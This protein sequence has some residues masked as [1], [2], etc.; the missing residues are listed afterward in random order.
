MKQVGNDFLSYHPIIAPTLS[1]VP[2]EAFDS[3]VE[4]EGMPDYW[5]RKKLYSYISCFYPIVALIG[6]NPQELVKYF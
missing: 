1:M 2:K 6:E 5:W 4:Q 3:I